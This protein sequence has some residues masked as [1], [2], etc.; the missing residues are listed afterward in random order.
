MPV[1]A[2]PAAVRRRL[3]GYWKMELMNVALVPA[4]CFW[5]AA[6]AGSP[7]SWLTAG[8]LVPTCGLLA[9]GGRY[10][11][12]KA[13]AAGGGSTALPAALRLARACRGPLLILTVAAA[14]AVA[15]D[16]LAVRLSAGTGD[17]VAAVVAAVLAVLEYVNYYHRQLQHFDN[18]ADFRRLLRGEGFRVAHLRADL[19]RAARRG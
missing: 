8:C 13:K 11:R 2:A 17:R 18:A 4:F 3:G 5:L 15:V 16:L 9:V 6:E 1:P 14:V 10:W 12:A 19:D 7:A